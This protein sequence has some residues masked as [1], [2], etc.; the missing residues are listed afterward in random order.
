MVVNIHK[1]TI[2]LDNKPFPVVSY[3]RSVTDDLVSR[4]GSSEQGQT[5]LDLLKA[6][7]QQS[8]RGG[9]FQRVFDDPEKVSLI[10]NA[11]F[12]KLD[13]RLYPT[14]AWGAGTTI[15]DDLGSLGILDWCYLKGLIYCSYKLANPSNTGLNGMFKLDPA[16]GTVTIL[17]LPT[18]LKNASPL[19]LTA[20]GDSIFIGASAASS[21]CGSY[22]YDGVTTFT[23]VTLQA[24]GF[25]VFNDTLY[26]LGYS[27]DFY[28]VT[29][30]T[31]T[32]I[33]CGS[34]ISQ[35]G[36][37]G[38]LV[39]GNRPYHDWKVFNNALYIAME[40]GLYRF[41]GTKVYPVLDY[42]T[43]ADVNNF[44][45]L[46]V[47]NGRLYYNIKNKL[48]QFDG[49]NV[50]ELQDFT[51]AYRINYIVGGVDR[52][53]ISTTVNT[54]ISY[55]DK[56]VTPGTYTYY[57]AI[58]CYNGVGF[59]LY[60][61]FSSYTLPINFTQLTLIPILGKV[62]AFLPD[63][64]LNGSSEE[65][66]NGYKK[67]VLDL[68][69]EF[70]VA[71]AGVNIISSEMDNDYPSV[72][73]VING[74][75]INYIGPPP[76][77]HGA[78]LAVYFQ[79]FNDSSWS[80]WELVWSN[81]TD[82]DGDGKSGVTNDYLLHEQDTTNPG[83][84]LNT[85]P[86]VYNK[87]RFK[88]FMNSGTVTPSISDLTLRYSIQPRLRYKWLLTLD[89][90]GADTRHL[91]TA[92]GSDG[93]LE[94]RKSVVLR[95]VIYDAYR[96]KLPILFYDFD[97]TELSGDSLDTLKGTDFISVR[98]VIAVQ[99][100]SDLIGK[101]R[102]YM[103]SSVTYDDIDDTTA[104]TWFSTGFREGIGGASSSATIVDGSQVRKS[105]AVYIK[106]I[107]NERYIV[108]PNTT[109]D[110]AGQAGYSDIPSQIT[111]D[112]VEL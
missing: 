56:V 32:P 102:N 79:Y 71:A 72:S 27:G 99:N 44:R 55:S 4:F 63:V 68:S 6:E 85:A 26:L 25:M 3:L 14:P 41:D 45:Y 109:N 24:S 67:L 59:F 70:V 19:K 107:R 18:A 35:V 43:A 42:G 9:M 8:F 28:Q 23:D 52:L 86:R 106:A 84:T 15:T 33:T 36:D 96:N 100:S 91:T 7:T 93:A 74:L 64:Y 48:F 75:L 62:Y 37:P 66:S 61:S 95:K 88:V 89:L 29:N 92:T 87:I 31:A 16:S 103:I 105:H 10:E 80:A 5:N 65:R 38:P 11:Y 77:D 47:F 58:F 73:K 17:T 12:N 30:A 54:G 40:S 51:D 2:F 57:H 101:W 50:E 46:A 94:D 81:S 22:R 34:K 82:R 20:Y 83:V 49:I 13:E 111:L 76:T 97:Y 108:D 90:A 53:W 39:S 60:R 78:A 21:V 112:L 110:N 98:D 1:N 69:Q 104:F